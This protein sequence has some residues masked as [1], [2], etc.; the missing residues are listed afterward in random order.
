MIMHVA[1]EYADYA[2]KIMIISMKFSFLTCDQ[3]DISYS[4]SRLKF[5]S[6]LQ[7]V[8]MLN[9]LSTCALPQVEFECSAISS[10]K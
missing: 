8:L 6:V 2:Q 1:L 10:G 5:S 7:P 9:V 3:I 4:L